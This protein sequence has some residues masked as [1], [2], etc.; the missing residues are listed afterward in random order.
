MMCAAPTCQEMHF[1]WS[2]FI[3]GIFI[4]HVVYFLGFLALVVHGRSRVFRNNLSIARPKG[5]HIQKDRPPLG[6]RP[7]FIADEDRLSEVEG[8]IVRYQD[9]GK[10]VPDEWFSEAQWLRHR[11][12]THANNSHDPIY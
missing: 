5:R 9:A 3:M 4:T 7:R 8:A 12:K 10:P 2:S 11:L 1:H 6:L